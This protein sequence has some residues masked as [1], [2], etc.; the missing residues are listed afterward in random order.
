MFAFDDLWNLAKDQG[1]VKEFYPSG[2][3]TAGFCKKTKLFCKIF[4]K[5][6]RLQGCLTCVVEIN[7]RAKSRVS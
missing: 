2:P 3:P 1:V 7:L 5:A 4:K 6:A